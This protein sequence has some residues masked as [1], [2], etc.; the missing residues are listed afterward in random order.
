MD[1]N[2]LRV[3]TAIYEEGSLTHAARRLHLTQPTISHACKKLRRQ[4]GDPL[5]IRK[6]QGMLPTKR[7]HDLYQAITPHLLALE[8]VA[9]TTQAFDPCLSDRKFTLCASD[10]G[11]SHL[12]PE[13]LARV[14]SAGPTLSVE[15]VPLDADSTA[16]HLTL[17]TVDA[18]VT[19]ADL[20]PH[21]H[22]VVLKRDQYCFAHH[23]ELNQLINDG[24]LSAVDFVFTHASRR[25]QDAV[26]RLQ[27][28]GLTISSRAM[29]QN[30]STLPQI[31][32]RARMATVVPETIARHWQSTW[33]SI[34]IS[35]LPIMT[36]LQPQVRLYRRKAPP[37][38]DT[39]WFFNLILETAHFLNQAVGA[40]SK[41]YDP[42]CSTIS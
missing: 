32:A 21:T 1:L 12:F 27:E 36:T 24:N 40:T 19:T 14:S 42:S 22:S 33:P 8:Q 25:H 15:V 2:L 29:V 34:C 7:A 38:P 10:I 13:V 9:E 26:Q 4:H 17:G 28:H 16:E 3:F 6:A 41:T 31:L 18:A 5:F 20:G 30:F 11:E 35:P 39:E 37:S 23:P